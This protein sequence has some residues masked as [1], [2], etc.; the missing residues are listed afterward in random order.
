[1]WFFMITAHFSMP[2]MVA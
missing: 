1:M 2:D